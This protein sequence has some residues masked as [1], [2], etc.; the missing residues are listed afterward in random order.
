MPDHLHGI[1]R[2]HGVLNACWTLNPSAAHVGDRGALCQGRRFT[3]PHAA[4]EPGARPPGAL[5]T[6]K[7]D[8]ATLFL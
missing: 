4:G 6:T 1:A 2:A 5:L 7:A 8:H 3:Q